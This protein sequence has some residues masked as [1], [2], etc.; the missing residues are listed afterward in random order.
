M[1]RGVAMVKPHPPGQQDSGALRDLQVTCMENLLS[2]AGERIYF[3]DLQSRFL[4]VSQSWIAAYAPGLRLADIVGKSDADFFSEQHA[5]SARRDEERIIRTGE[6]MAGKIARETYKDRPFA[7]VATTKVPLRDSRGQIIGTFGVS[8]DITAQIRAENSLAE[9]ANQLSGQ[10]ERLRELDRLKDEFIASVSHE[11]RTPLTSIIG[12]IELLR[13]EDDP[14]PRAAHF[15]DVIER[16]A[17]RLLRLVGDLLFLSRLQSG[18][19]VVEFRDADLADIAARAVEEMRP[20][21]ERK[22]IS[23][24]LSTAPVPQF[25]MDP[26]RIAQLLG[27]L[28]S[29]AIKFTPPGGK[30]EVRLG[31]DGDQAVLAVA[32]TGIG[33]PAADR[34]AVFERFFRTEAATRRAI[35]GT[36]LGLT[37][38][39][40]IVEAHQGS[41][42]VTSEEGHGSTFTVFLPTSVD[43][44]A[45]PAAPGPA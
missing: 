12:Y 35:Q 30:V 45:P 22:H 5:A 4:L 7:W 40:A 11:L 10:N 44:T 13:D 18:E 41:I 15:T 6:P 2:A 14:G 42:T 27:N 38:T 23:L 17:Q 39:K 25:S 26:V 34:E 43:R 33:I 31:P 37:V 21:A 29:N 19:M 1:L 8:R 3:K 16:N 28:V 36:G 9:H 20:Q 32:D 24:I